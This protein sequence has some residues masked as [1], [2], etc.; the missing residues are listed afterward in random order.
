MV[1]KKCYTGS[2][3]CICNCQPWAVRRGTCEVFMCSGSWENPQFHLRLADVCSVAVIP[4]GLFQQSFHLISLYYAILF[5][6]CFQN[7]HVCL[8]YTNC[9]PLQAFSLPHWN[10]A[11]PFVCGVFSSLLCFDYVVW[12]CQYCYKQRWEQLQ[13]V[14]DQT[15]IVLFGRMADTMPSEDSAEFW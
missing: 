13:K 12:C 7:C 1:L 9:L 3:W 8:I 11:C 5:H 14:I 4:P 15:I 10:W 2:P 6:R